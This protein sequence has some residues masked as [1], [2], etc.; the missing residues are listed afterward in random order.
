MGDEL[1]MG[2]LIDIVDEEWMRD[3]LPFTDLTLPPVFVAR[4]D[5]T[6]DT[7]IPLPDQ[8]PQPA[9]RDAW[10]DLALVTQ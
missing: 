2:V 4:T 3:T 9:D 6:E 8:E 1:N 10:R 5:D 7:I